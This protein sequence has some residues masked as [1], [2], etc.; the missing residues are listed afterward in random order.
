M[1]PYFSI[2]TVTKDTEKKIDLTIRSVLSQSFK[3]FE[4]LIVDGNSTDSTFDK[5]NRYKKIKILKYT[6]VVTKISTK[7][8][9]TQQAKRRATIYL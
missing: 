5:I 9:I 1:K 6:D 2:I 7:A 4:Y 8:L 3:N